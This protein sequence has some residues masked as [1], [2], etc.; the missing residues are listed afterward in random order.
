MALSLAQKFINLGMPSP[1]AVEFANQINT[2]T[3]NWKRLMWN[4]MVPQLK[5]GATASEVYN[6]RLVPY[7]SAVKAAGF[8]LVIGTMLPRSDLSSPQQAEWNA[9]NA[10]IRANWATISDVLADYQA[11]STIGPFAAASNP[12]F[13][14][15]GIHPSRAGYGILAPIFATAVNMA[16]SG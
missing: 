16:T 4:S 14:P 6:N 8:R 1:L 10:L 12:V 9:Y 15:D 3:Y 2:G 13:Y 5:A 7:C 11:N